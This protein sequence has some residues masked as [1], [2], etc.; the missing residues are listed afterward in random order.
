MRRAAMLALLLNLLASLRSAFRTRAELALEN[1]ALRQQ[2]A[3]FHRSAPPPRL[4][5]AD[6][7]FWVG[8]SQIWSR[9]ADALIIVKP[10]TVVR[11]HRAGFRLF[12]RWKSRC[13]TPRKDE[14]S[15]EVK[16]P[17]R[18][19]AKAN[20][21]WGAPKIH[22]EL[23]ML[24]FVISERSV[25]RYMPKPPRQPPSQTWKRS[26]TSAV[27]RPRSARSTS[28]RRGNEID[29]FGGNAAAISAIADPQNCVI[30][31]SRQSTTLPAF[32]IHQQFLACCKCV[33]ECL[34][35]RDSQLW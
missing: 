28:R 34:E 30:A 33:T 17:I 23:L 12:G 16:R 22:G 32:P 26:C 29:S 9:W 24:G 19:M 25:S 31:S 20:P 13:H 10:D 5:L 3:T 11:W 15:S 4:R 27:S 35:C 6:R 1:L 8:L 18:R 21:L 7:A 14:V 2:L